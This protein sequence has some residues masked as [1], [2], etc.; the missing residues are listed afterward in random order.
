[1]PWQFGYYYQ[2]LFKQFYVLGPGQGLLTAAVT[3]LA[4]SSWPWWACSRGCAACA[5]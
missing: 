3:V 5:R 2:F 1:L 4:R